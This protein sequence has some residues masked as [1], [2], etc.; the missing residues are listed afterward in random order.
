MEN[1]T[2]GVEG[3]EKDSKSSGLLTEERDFKLPF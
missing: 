1:H 3:E 2:R